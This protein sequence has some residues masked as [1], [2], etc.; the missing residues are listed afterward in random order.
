[1]IAV[2]EFVIN[3]GSGASAGD[4]VAGDKGIFGVV[5]TTAA[6]LAGN[7]GAG[8]AGSIASDAEQLID[9]TIQI[10]NKREMGT[11]CSFF[12]DIV[13]LVYSFLL[14]SKFVDLRQYV[15]SLWIDMDHVLI[16][17]RFESFIK[18]TSRDIYYFLGE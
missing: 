12:K 2:S 8:L 11:I 17:T 1:L 15:S 4:G 14:R 5:C 16:I 6:G 3:A 10:A 9:V 13:R 7:G 18:L